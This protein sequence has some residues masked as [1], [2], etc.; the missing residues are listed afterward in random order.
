MRRIQGRNARFVT[1]MDPIA[2]P[3]GG[4]THEGGVVELSGIEPGPYRIVIEPHS[5]QLAMTIRSVSI[6]RHSATETTIEL[7]DLIEQSVR[8]VEFDGRPIEGS[9]IE[10]LDPDGEVLEITT[11]PLDPWTVNMGSQRTGLL[12]AEDTTNSDGRVTLPAPV[13]REIALRAFGHHEPILVPG[14]RASGAEQEIRLPPTG[15]IEVRAT[16]VDLIASWLRNNAS[17]ERGSRLPNGG[18]GISVG[19][20]SPARLV[21]PTRDPR[22]ELPQDQGRFDAT[23]VAILKRVP[24][25]EWSLNL[26]VE[27]LD[28]NG[29]LI[30]G[31][32][33]LGRLTV[34]AGE[35]VVREVDLSG[36]RGATFRGRVVI[37]GSAAIRSIG[38]RR[39]ESG[40]YPATG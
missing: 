2:A 37:D 17:S 23:G 7:V 34:T 36:E 3:I 5:E 15:T 38:A 31:F 18:P 10:V 8:L 35:T 32:L 33:D 30:Q 16:P 24:V 22:S 40:S 25:G 1:R 12:I 14:L 28:S 29:D 6:D 27:H 4:L 11:R 13:G 26:T 9:R 19:R 20:S 39:V 21:V